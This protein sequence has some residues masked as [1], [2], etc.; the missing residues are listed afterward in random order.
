MRRG[1]KA[2]GPLYG[3]QCHGAGF[4]ILSASGFLDGYRGALIAQ[5]AARSVRLKYKKLGQLVNSAEKR[6]QE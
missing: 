2:G 6:A 5:M 3:W 4:R 1:S